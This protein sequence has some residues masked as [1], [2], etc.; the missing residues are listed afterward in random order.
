MACGSAACL[1][2]VC[3]RVPSWLLS[4]SVRGSAEL[5]NRKGYVMDS[6]DIASVIGQYVK[7]VPVGNVYKG[8]CPFHEDTR[9]SLAVYPEGKDGQRKPHFHCFGCGAHGDVYDF[10]KRLNQTDYPHAKALVD[11]EPNRTNARRAAAGVKSRLRRVS[12]REYECRDVD[13]KVVAVHHRQDYVASDGTK[14]KQIWWTRNGK[15]G[16]DGMSPTE[17][18]LWG[19]D[20]LRSLSPF[21]GDVIVTEGE[22]AAERLREA[23]YA[24]VGTYGAN[25]C[26][27]NERLKELVALSERVLLWPD[28]D[29]AGRQHMEEIACGLRRLGKDPFLVEWADAPPHGDAA[30]FTGDL[31]ALLA[32]AA[33]WRPIRLPEIV[34]T[35]RQLRDISHDAL[36]ALYLHNQPPVLFRRGGGLVR[37]EYDESAN[38]FIATVG[39]AALRGYLAR[40]ADFVRVAKNERRAVSPPKDVVQDIATLVDTRFPPLVGVT[41]IPV[42]RPD[43]T[44]VERAGYDDETRLCYCPD[45]G[46]VIP[47]IPDNP[48]RAEIEAA[49]D[50]ILEPLLDFPFDSEASR[51]TAVAALLTPLL[52]P[53]IDGQVPLI[54]VDKP[55]AGTGAGLFTNLVGIL[56]TGSEPAMMPAPSRQEEWNK[57]ILAVLMRGQPVVVIDN[58]E[59]DLYSPSLAAVLTAKFYQSRVLGRSEMVSLPDRALWMAT[60][61]N[62][63]LHGDLPRRC[64]WARMNANTSRPWLRDKSSFKHSD[65]LTWTRDHRNELLAAVFTVARAWLLAG[66]PEAPGTMAIG[67]FESYCRVVGGILSYIGIP[68]FL[69]NLGAMYDEMDSETPQWDAFLE[70]WHDIIGDTPV[71]TKQLIERIAQDEELRDSLPSELASNADARHLGTAIA[72]RKDVR[73]P[74]GFRITKAG[75]LRR[76]ARWSC[77]F[78]AT[79]SHLSTNECESCESL[80]V[81]THGGISDT[82]A[83]PLGLVIGSDSPD[84]HLASEQCESEDPDGAEWTSDGPRHRCWTCDGHDYWQRFDGEW[85]CQTCHPKPR[86][87]HRS[88]VEGTASS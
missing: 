51:A 61:N 24:A 75:E 22:K 3:T 42:L 10:V 18:P 28:N 70:A 57:T 45:D 25:V 5:S 60:G 87:Q 4:S 74:S 58:I 41:R 29:E 32:T 59:D 71:T 80:G 83:N 77:Q 49:R 31:S 11:G 50:L 39:E 85:V 46:L 55:Q 33:S 88:D 7:L 37:V 9:P 76:A 78:T 79:D 62:I 81:G 52:R 35:D 44:L 69:E 19:I 27:V 84:S 65:L 14:S 15:K 17:L 67:G 66:R 23:G 26:P 53:L 64:L 48:T 12:C 34:V 54:I 20:V 43:G 68:G 30:D 2:T 86:D 63:T 38:P 6:R 36:D 56:A 8:L 13:G 72:K 16:L 1:A 73:F 21:L 40:S 47:P 82:T